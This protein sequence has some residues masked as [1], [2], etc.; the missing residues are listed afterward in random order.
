MYTEILE[1][2]K[3]KK[4]AL[5]G[6]GKEG[7]STYK[8]IRNHLKNQKLTIL[9]Q[10]V[11]LAKTENNLLEDP[12]VTLIL[13]ENYLDKLD[14]YDIII[15]TPGISFKNI[16][17]KNIKNKIT[18][19]IDLF[20]ENID[21]KTIGIT[22]TK[23]KSTTSSLIYKIIKDQ[24]FDTYLCG[25]I[26]IPI[27]DYIEKINRNSIVVVEM[28]AYHTEFIKKSPHIGIILNLLEEHLDYFGNKEK[29]FQ[30]KL[31]M[32]K[33]Q[34]ESDYA[35][36]S[37][38]NK[39]L[40]EIVEKGKYK[41][42]LVKILST[43]NIETIENNTIVCDENYIYVKEDDNL[44]KLYDTTNQKKLLGRHNLENIMF[45][46][47]VSNIL[48]LDNDK[49]TLSINSFQPL[50]HRMEFVGTYRN[51]DFYDDSIA[52]IPDATIHCIETLKNVNT[53]IIGGMDRNI[54]YSS[55][56][57]YLNTSKIENIICLPDTGFKIGRKLINKKVFY[58][59]NIK[60]AVETAYEVT[61][62]KEICLLS[63]A[64]SSYN[65]YKNFEAKGNDYKKMINLLK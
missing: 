10:N 16:D 28:S 18:S 23:G 25:N 54:D 32:F 8:F 33:Y 34:N 11:N 24:N 6:F 22:G 13:G 52:T 30:S 21:C 5:L 64:A 63:P 43:K 15:K 62:K 39:T 2:I 40:K 51:I 45:A 19:Q 49:T 56:I 42:H 41:S 48:H 35:I 9:D 14:I 36:Y 4:I 46:F 65:Q 58:K 37:L 7:K 3:N 26:G 1:K 57:E 44:K 55:L 12:N 47:A 50:E 60:E 61:K 31:N 53:L 59:K 38:D 27:F 29:Y 20:L 17:L